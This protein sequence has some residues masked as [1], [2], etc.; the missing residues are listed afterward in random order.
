METSRTQTAFHFDS[1]P[2]ILIV[3]ARFYDQIADLQ[4]QGV[5]EV[6]NRVQATHEV[7]RVPG[8]LEIPAAISYAMKALDFDPI[9]RRAEGYIAL[10]CVMKGGTMHDQ[11][12]A[13]ESARGLQDLAIRRSLAIGNGI[14]T[15]NT[16]EQALERADPKRLNRGGDAAAACLRMIELKHQFRLSPKRRWTAKQSTSG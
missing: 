7:V 11:V 8:A 6:L 15:C 10:G 9:R 16:M 12:V 5:M 14:L 1:P 2:H 3:E 13:L 4:M